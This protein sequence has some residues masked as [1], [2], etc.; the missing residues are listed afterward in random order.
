MFACPS[1]LEPWIVDVNLRCRVAQR[2]EVSNRNR[3][4]Q[5]GWLRGVG[6]ALELGLAS[7]EPSQEAR[8]IR[9]KHEDAHTLLDRDPEAV[10]LVDPCLVGTAGHVAPPIF[11]L[12]IPANGLPQAALETDAASIAQFAGQF[13]GVDR[14]IFGIAERRVEFGNMH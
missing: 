1:G 5:T 7:I 10:V 3:R 11:L 14:V 9:V 8:I 4:R 2:G 12:N 6:G 13:R